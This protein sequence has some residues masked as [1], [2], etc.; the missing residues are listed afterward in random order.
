MIKIRVFALAE[1]LIAKSV[2]EGT[3]SLGGTSNPS[4]YKLIKLFYHTCTNKNL[5]NLP[6]CIPPSQPKYTAT[7]KLSS[8]P[9]NGEGETNVLILKY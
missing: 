9:P 6:F 4:I 2:Q 8:E 3:R 7:Q 5:N 1:T